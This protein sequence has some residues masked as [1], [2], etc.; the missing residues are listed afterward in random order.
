[1]RQ[2]IGSVVC[3]TAGLLGLL[4][5]ACGEAG[6]RS[7]GERWELVWS[8][9][10]E[11]AKGASPDASKW[12]FDVGG[13]GWGNQ[14]LEFNTDSPDNVS[15][16]GDG[17]LAITAR[18]QALGN[19]RFTSG[20]IQTRGRFSQRYGRVEA[21]VK[22]PSGRGVWPAF[23]MLGDDFET[24][25]WPA[26]GEIDILELRGQEPSVVVG[27]LHGPGYAGGDAITSIHRLK[28]GRF[29]ADF[30]RFAVEWDP[31]RIVFL[32]DDEPWQTVT[33]D[34]VLA[35]GPW[36]FDQPFFLLLNVA[37]GGMFVGPP[38]ATTT[39]PQSMVVDWVRVFRR[40]P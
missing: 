40:A 11:G 22:L 12:G 24:A 20:R 8:D 36:V 38:D 23:W 6:G 37:V 4:L 32:V 3:G 31:A 10:F 26:C 35:K 15:L 28:E 17:H 39:L 13:D 7:A 21:R 19:N 29:D 1:M 33:A 5:A 9:E 30:H 34:R 2:R 25:G 18:R 14:Q 16:D 27:S